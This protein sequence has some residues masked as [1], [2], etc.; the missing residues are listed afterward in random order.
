MKKRKLEVLEANLDDMNPQW[1]ESL[2]ER[3]FAAGAL[4]VT[5]IPAFMKKN[6]P[7]VVLQVLTKPN[8]RQKL[9]GI[10]FEETTTLGIRSYLVNRY[11][12]PREFRKVKTPYGEVTVKISRDGRGRVLNISPEY[13]SCLALAKKKK[14]PLKTIY[15]ATLRA[16]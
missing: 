16:A 1:Y 7:A 12:L 6:R 5:L 8:L 9:L 11:E 4:D 15:A 3:L 14:V 13:A 2:M 10:I